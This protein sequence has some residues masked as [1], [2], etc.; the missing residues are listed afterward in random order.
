MECVII[1]WPRTACWME[2]PPDAVLQIVLSDAPVKNCPVLVKIR[3]HS[4]CTSATSRQNLK[5]R[6]WILELGVKGRHKS[7]Q[8]YFLNCD[9]L[10]TNC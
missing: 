6:P 10:T 8:N 1:S 7:A 2:G 5:R 4:F 9:T 3:T